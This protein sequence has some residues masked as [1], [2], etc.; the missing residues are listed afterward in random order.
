M[1]GLALALLAAVSITA[2][3]QQHSAESSKCSESANTQ[4]QMN[5]CASAE[6]KRAD[7]DLNRT[8]QAL[9]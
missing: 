3:A 5:E 8:Y 7:A 9:L 2:S 1:S 4:A 6:L